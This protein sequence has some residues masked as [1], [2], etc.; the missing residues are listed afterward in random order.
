M[1]APHGRRA[2]PSA[3]PAPHGNPRF[4]AVLPDMPDAPDAGAIAL[5]EVLGEARVAALPRVRRDAKG[6]AWVEVG[7]R[8][9]GSAGGRHRAMPQTAPPTPSNLRQQ[10][11]AAVLAVHSAGWVIDAGGVDALGCR[12]DGTPLITD[13]SG[14]HRSTS[15]QERVQDLAWIDR[16][17]EDGDGTHARPIPDD[18]EET[19]EF[20]PLRGLGLTAGL[21]DAAS[22]EPIDDEVPAQAFAP[23]PAAPSA[24]ASAPSA[25]PA[26]PS[27][28][29]SSPSTLPSSPSAPPSS[30]LALP[31]PP[32]EVVQPTGEGRSGQLSWAEVLSPTEHR[33]RPGA[34]GARGRDGRRR[35]G[36]GSRGGQRG[37]DEHRGRGRR[38]AKAGRR[39]DAQLSGGVGRWT[40]AARRL[41]V[42]IGALL[43]VATLAVAII[44]VGQPWGTES[45]GDRSPQAG[46]AVA[47]QAASTR[48]TAEQ[49]GD[50]RAA[51][52]ADPAEPSAADPSPANPHAVTQASGEPAHKRLAEQLLAE[53]RDYI[54]GQSPSA[55]SVPGSPAARQ[56]DALRADIADS[57]V[58]EW[59][60]TVHSA[61]L[62][63]LG[64]GNAE[65][66]VRATEGDI[67]V[68]RPNG[69]ELT[70]PGAGEVVWTVRLERG[71]ER[72]QIVS[73]RAST[74]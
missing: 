10:L 51:S 19:G 68:Q 44:V 72:W 15:P 29:P 41:D 6:I 62:V 26:S 67:V 5:L 16:V 47:R 70:S 37:E 61:R 34:G 20:S 63:E 11:E 74:P 33:P 22:P 54:T 14:L 35:A 17:L 7:E 59:P 50:P 73:V 46:Q 13:L 1:N 69:T 28:L 24:L 21:E 38:G 49:P 66:T 25:L 43:V 9:D 31:S 8:A 56:D 3:D 52:A 60:I 39:R 48:T 42:V 32:S 71:E 55:V 58:K 27:P 57:T 40:S 53:R 4:R 45:R 12:A 30:P 23:L 2:A 18:Q 65:L 36:P 64:S